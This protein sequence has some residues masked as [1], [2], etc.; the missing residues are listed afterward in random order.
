[1]ATALPATPAGLAVA[2][3]G[4]SDPVVSGRNCVVGRRR[5]AADGGGG[6]RQWRT[7]L[8]S[9]LTVLGSSETR[10]TELRQPRTTAVTNGDQPRTAVTDQMRQKPEQD[11]PALIPT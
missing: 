8:R 6:R 11:R 5:T 2:R 4:G 3:R 10:L 7:V 9:C 1:V